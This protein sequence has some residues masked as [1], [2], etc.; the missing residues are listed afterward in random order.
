[1]AVSRRGG[2]VEHLIDPEAVPT[3]YRGP[4]GAAELE[5]P[6]NS[7][8]CRQPVLRHSAFP[9]KRPSAIPIRMP[10]GEDQSAVWSKAPPHQRQQHVRIHKANSTEDRI[11]ATEPPVS[12]GKEV[13]SRATREGQSGLQLREPHPRL[14]DVVDRHVD[15]VHH[16]PTTRESRS[17]GA[18]STTKL[19]DSLIF[20]NPEDLGCR[21]T[22]R[23]LAPLEP[24]RVVESQNLANTRTGTVNPHR[25][26]TT[27]RVYLPINEQ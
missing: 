9:W 18:D 23:K 24:A 26:I 13:F 8:G 21:A 17:I 11:G 1:M 19:Q 27:V 15:S 4:R 25:V 6:D 10:N 22:S 5:S 3:Q 2:Y 14:N 7:S 20:E 12:R 16:S